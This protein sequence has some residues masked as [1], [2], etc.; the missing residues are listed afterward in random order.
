MNPVQTIYRM[1]E[2]LKKTPEQTREDLQSAI[3]SMWDN[4]YLRALFV[5]RPSVE[6]FILVSN[7]FI[8]RYMDE[9]DARQP[10]QIIQFPQLA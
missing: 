9:Q 8:K 6:V 4:G 3:N 5:S 1:A 7:S 10:A 2:I